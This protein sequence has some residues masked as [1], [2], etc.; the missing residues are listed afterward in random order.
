[1]DSIEEIAKLLPPLASADEL[2]EAGIFP[3]VS[4]LNRLRLNGIGP[5]YIRISDRIIRYPKAEVIK[6]LKDHL[7]KIN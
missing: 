5:N 2:V 6:F 4:T 3:C 7:N 1:V